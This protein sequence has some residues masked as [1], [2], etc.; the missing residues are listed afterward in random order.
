MNRYVQYIIEDIREAINEEE[1]SD[2][3]GFSNEN[4]L[5]YLNDAQHRLQAKIQSQYPMVFVTQAEFP[6]GSGSS[7]IDLPRDAYLGNKVIDVKFSQAGSQYFQRLKPSFI[8]RIKNEFK[9]YPREY[10]R[11]SGSLEIY[12]TSSV[13]GVIRLNYVSR[14]PELA[15]RSGQV[16]AVTNN[17]TAIT[18]FTLDI[19]TDAPDFSQLNKATR[20]SIVDKEGNIKAS[21]LQ[22]TIDSSTGVCTVDTALLEGED[23]IAG[24]YILAN[25]FATTHSKFDVSIERYLLSYCSVK[26]LQQAGSNELAE[27]AQTLTSI[28][29]EIVATYADITGDFFAIPDIINSEDDWDY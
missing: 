15:L 4:F 22:L 20:Y 24:D 14:I 18:D 11:K 19:V 29:N 10:L 23:I 21:H 13:S 1:F 12:P 27:E 16:S 7:K 2:S 8:S 5:R 28:E 6:V 17:G 25:P 26:M 3:I 9:G